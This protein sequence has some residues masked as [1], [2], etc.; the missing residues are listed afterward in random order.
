MNLFILSTA[1]Q[2]FFLSKAPELI[3]KDVLI[4]T[5]T[6][7]NQ[8]HQILVHLKEFN[9]EE[10]VI[11]KT[12]KKNDSLVHVKVIY[13]RLWLWWFK[14]RR[15]NFKEIY[16]G[17]YS[18]LYHLSIVGE[19]EH[20]SKIFLLY[21]G[22]QIISVA[23]NRKNNNLNVR[24]LPDSFTRLK[25]IQPKIE[26][27]NFVGPFSLPVNPG[28]TFKTFKKKNH[29]HHP[30]LNESKVVFVG[31]PL[32]EIGYVSR[33]YYLNNL[34]EVKKKFSDKE[35]LYIPHPREARKQ[36]KKI[37]ELLKIKIFDNIFEE[38]YFNSS[39][40]PKT[41]VSHYSSVLGNLCYLEAKTDLHAIRIPEA[42]F[43]SKK[44]YDNYQINFSFL[45][46]LDHSR[47]NII[48]F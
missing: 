43:L 19:Y 7:K 20:K 37:A 21:D 29:Q 45:E 46:Q 31:Q 10:I 3:K 23:H 22:M 25:F 42:K 35:I 4:L 14:I 44:G 47:M 28:D 9:W 38:E 13:F 18:N 36:I 26:S 17:S 30:Q 34:K 48:E 39:V 12:P 24:T 16:I 33:D 2:A 27:L 32:V 8:V 6:N 15:I 41:V 1:T 40:F 5:V 11:L